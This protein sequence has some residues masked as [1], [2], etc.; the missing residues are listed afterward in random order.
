M[1]TASV[2]FEN[3]ETVAYDFISQVPYSSP[4]S[5]HTQCLH[6]RHS[7]KVLSLSPIHLHAKSHFTIPT[8]N[9]TQAF[10]MFEEELSDTKAQVASISLI[11]INNTMSNIILTIDNVHQYLNSRRR[12]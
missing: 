10:L 8:A 7:T 9:D 12:P 5:I 6:L 3:A 11:A 4:L 2:P 1:A